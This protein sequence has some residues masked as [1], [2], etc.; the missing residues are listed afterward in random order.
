METWHTPPPST[1][2]STVRVAIRQLRSLIILNLR[3]QA[4]EELLLQLEGLAVKKI[5]AGDHEVSRDVE[6]SLRECGFVCLP[7][8][9]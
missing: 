9:A 1:N 5:L 6:H 8:R 3:A 7:G 2:S 4:A